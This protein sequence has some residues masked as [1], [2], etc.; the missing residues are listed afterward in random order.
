M[1]TCRERLR[2]SKET[3]RDVDDRA[4]RAH[5][6]A[7][8]LAAKNKALV[9]R[10]KTL[11]AAAALASQASTA[12][13]QSTTVTSTRTVSSASSSVLDS[14]AI[15]ASQEDEI[16][17][18]QQ[19]VELMKRAHRT[20]RSKQDRRLEA[21]RDVVEQTRAQL[22]AFHETLFAKEKT[23]RSL[24]L[25]L[26]KLKRAVQDL[27]HAQQTNEHM[28][29]MVFG[30]GVRVLGHSSPRAHHQRLSPTHHHHSASTSIL[31]P[32]M[33]KRLSTHRIHDTLRQL[34]Y[35]PTFSKASA[36]S[37]HNKP[38]DGQRELLDHTSGLHATAHD[39]EHELPLVHGTPGRLVP[40]P[41]PANDEKRAI[42]S[43]AR[44][45]R[46]HVYATAAASP[47]RQEPSSIEPETRIDQG[48]GSEA[49]DE[50]ED[51]RTCELGDESDADAEDERGD[52]DAEAGGHDGGER[53]RHDDSGHD[54]DAHSRPQKAADSETAI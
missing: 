46:S 14:E 36:Q 11:E 22:D 5:Q 38:N 1:R 10:I 34:G 33:A 39:D 21:S 37:P 24:Y 44:T 41:P 51:H 4:T 17:R 28:Q 7:V 47:G 45:P 2:Q 18:L 42:S 25:Q 43:G 31:P 8:D 54:W 23:I 20:E 15:I 40:G 12:S 29:S 48:D 13:L 35:V 53:W 9:E 32:A 19:R 30:N 50:T 27:T 3:Q 49:V 52:S 16:T 26:K 6:H